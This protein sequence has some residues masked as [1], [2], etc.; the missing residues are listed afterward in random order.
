MVERGFAKRLTQAA[1]RDLQTAWWAARFEL[2]L[3]RRIRADCFQPAPSVDS[4]HLLVRPRTGM[5]RGS[6]QR[7]LWSLLETAYSTPS[8]PV[9]SVVTG[10]LVR[11]QAGRALSEVGIEATR[12]ALAVTVTEWADLARSLGEWVDAPSLPSQ[13]IRPGKE[14]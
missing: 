6:T 1:P 13:L 14:R 4:A 9:R 12:P 5:R 3:L 10:L 2:R 8:L 11:R 7:A